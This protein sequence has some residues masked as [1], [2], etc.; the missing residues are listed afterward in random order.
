MS[1][2]RSQALLIIVLLS[3]VL[4]WM[5]LDVSGSTN[6]IRDQILGVLS[7][8]QYALQK[9]VQAVSQVGAGSR[10]AAEL[11]AELEAAQQEIAD[12]RAQVI[13]LQEAQ[14]E[15]EYLRKELDFRRSATEGR[16]LVAQVIGYDTSGYLRYLIVDRGEDD[17]V[18][19]EMPVVASQGLVG[20]ISQTSASSAK[21][22]LITDPSSSVS[23]RIQ[24]TRD[25]GS[26]QGVLG[27]GL[28]MKYIPPDSEVVPGDVVLTSG[29]GGNFPRGLAVGQVINVS[30]TDADV[31]QEA[32]LVPAVNL[33]SLEA[34]SILLS[35]SPIDDLPEEGE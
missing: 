8:I 30:K 2:T 6:Q 15:N 16:V 4:A 24:R 29:L 10:S 23:V 31:F 5:V 1:E 22:M 21:V 12:L 13:L 28:V 11:E 20:R 9:L 33:N 19:P 35:F 25:T 14:I 17:G 27:G 3:V 7:P 34:V 32:A 18:R 26:V